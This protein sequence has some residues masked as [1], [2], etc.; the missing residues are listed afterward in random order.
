MKN[1]FLYLLSSIFL[2]FLICGNV[3]AD[4]DRTVNL[5]DVIP[6]H[7]GLKITYEE[8]NEKM[9][10]YLDMMKEEEEFTEEEYIE[11]ILIDNTYF[12]FMSNSNP[13]YKVN[14]HKEYL[15]FLQ[16][17]MDDILKVLGA[18]EQGC[19]GGHYSK[20]HNLC[21]AGTSPNKNSLYELID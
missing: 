19:N 9:S 20:K 4:S 6:L 1:T 3:S 7:V 15:D 2:V 10:Y 14:T 16:Y 12:M 18:K 8:F 5:T 21:I 13:H 17:Y 11:M